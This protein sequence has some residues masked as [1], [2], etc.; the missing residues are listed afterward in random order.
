[1]TVF[2][3]LFL[4]VFV[5]S[6]GAIVMAGVLALCGF[7]SRAFRTLRNCGVCLA[8]YLSVALLVNLFLPR[9]RLQLGEN[10]CDDDW[11]IAVAGGSITPTP[12]GQIY[13]VDFRVSSRARRVDQRE[14]GV[15]VQ[16]ADQ[17]GRHFDSLPDPS[18]VPFNT[19]L[20]PGEAVTTTRRFQI[21]PGAGRVEAL[22]VRSGPGWMIIGESN[23][24][25]SAVWLDPVLT[26][27]L[28]QP[29]PIH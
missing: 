1:M 27:A 11:C 26:H 25:P 7:P 23:F 2:D 19:R 6:A 18:E 4:A 16:L 9:R 8:L 10:L 15:T 13:A 28:T 22:I 21:P 17:H 20:H 5:A 14:N 29:A 3:L 12:E 24:H